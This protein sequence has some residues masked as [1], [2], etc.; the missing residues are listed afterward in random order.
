M[1]RLVGLDLNGRFDLAARDWAAEG[2]DEAQ[3]GNAPTRVRVIRGG[4]AAA[5]VV[6]TDN[7]RVAGPQAMLAPHGRG[8]GWGDRIGRAERR[9][10]LATAIDRFGLGEGDA[11]DLRAA[12]QALARGSDGLIAAVPD[13]PGFDEKAQAGMIAALS[14]PRSPARLLWRPVAAFLYLMDQGLIDR[15]AHGSRYRILIHSGAGLE[16]QTLTLRDDPD[17][18]GHAAPQRVGPGQLHRMAGLD[19]LYRKAGELLRAFN[20]AIPWA[21]CEASRLGPRLVTGEVGAGA[22]EVLRHRNSAW[23][24]ARAPGLS[25]TDLDLTQV[26]LPSAAQKVEATFLCTPLVAELAQALASSLSRNLGPVTVVGPEAVALGCLRAAR[27]IERGLPHYFDRLEPIA[28]A[29]LRGREPAFE[30]LIPPDAVVPANQEHVSPELGGFLWG[31]GKRAT[32]FYVL[33]GE[34]E[35]RHWR[36]EKDTAPDRDVPVALRIR[37]TPGQSWARLTAGATDWEPIARTPVALD[38]E[39]LAPIDLTPQE[40]LDK[41]RHQPPTVPNLLVEAPHLDLWLGADWA[42]N[43]LAAALARDEMRG[44]PV[45]ASQWASILSRSRRYPD[46]PRDRFWLVGTDGRLP[47]GLPDDVRQGFAR[48]LARLADTALSATL[49]RPLTDNAAMKAL[50]WC[51][52][53]CPG[54]VQDRMLDALETAAQGRQHPLLMPPHA[55]RVLRQGAGRAVTGADRLARLFGYLVRADLNTDTINALAMALTRREEAPQA[56]SRPL[57]DQFLHGLGQELIERVRARDFKLRFR[58]TLSAIAGLFRWRTREPFALLAAQD[59]VAEGLRR[60]LVKARDLLEKGD[61][62]QRQQK[63]DQIAAI[64]AYLDG[65]GDP[66]I[67]RRLEADDDTDES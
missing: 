49:R 65:E 62:P 8:D 32:E 19:A 44:R 57:V 55:I 29:V 9:H 26:E 33:K 16:V 60:S 66:D 58:N 39:T 47:D 45:S 51:F 6:T 7:R 34:A 12:R 43:G 3:D 4:T 35:I 31:R 10:S 42:G 11:A 18:P 59:P 25:S 61:V 63:L 64:I 36:V 46:P 23:L 53:L 54:E 37:Q 20:S 13:H 24:L 5:V 28:I 1:K 50:T 56:L 17:H 30:H 14:L 38:W 40:V 41:L 52:A 21:L 48:A 2:E 67:L 15:T 27:L 22:T